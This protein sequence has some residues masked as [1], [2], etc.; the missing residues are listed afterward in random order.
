MVAAIAVGA[1]A[2]GSSS[3]S[4]SSATSAGGGSTGTAS[5]SASTGS[6]SATGAPIKVGFLCSCSGEG[7]FNAANQGDE[8]AFKAWI[9][10]V[11][12]AGGL[13]GHPVK[14]IT[15]DDQGNPGT[16]ITNLQT[17]VSDHVD[18]IVDNSTVD[19]AWESAAHH[20]GIP[21]IG[22]LTNGSPFVTDSDFYGEGQTNDS[23]VNAIVDIA[24]QAGAKSIGAMYCA[25]AS[26]CAEITGLV[27]SAAKT[28][29]IK[30]SYNSAISATAPNYTA[31][32]LAA[33]DAGVQAVFLAD[34]AAV[35]IRFAGDCAAQGYN[36]M[37]VI[38]AAGAGANVLTS[39]GLKNNLWIQ[40]VDLPFWSTSP[41]IR[42]INSAMDKYYPGVRENPNLWYEDGVMTWVSGELL[43]AAVQ[44]SGL[45]ASATPSPAVITK[46][47]DALKNDT[48]GGLAPPLSFTAGQPHHIDCWFTGHVQNGVASVANNGQVSCLN[49]SSSTSS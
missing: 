30:N 33:K 32:C 23:I 38:E 6:S 49:G 14:V 4:S 21:V 43:K 47:L 42:T 29:G 8:D 27:K 10:V 22:V 44:H 25:E 13:A 5:S 24:K 7:G 34:A 15:E 17:V 1:A 31:Q 37:Y 20:S 16:S 12:A 9:N 46:G 45:T 2:C 41:L 28:A 11:N 40:S 18:A 19:T 39:P 36:P 48:L 35:N 26:Q 3:H